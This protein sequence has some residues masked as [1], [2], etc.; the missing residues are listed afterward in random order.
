MVVAIMPGHLSTSFYHPS[1]F[2]YL[3]YVVVSSYSSPLFSLEM[4][5]Q[6]NVFR[7]A[8]S[9]YNVS[10]LV[11]FLN[12]ISR[13]SILYIFT[14]PFSPFICLE[15]CRNI[16]QHL[17]SFSIWT[18]TFH[19]HAS[20]TCQS[21]Y[22]SFDT[23]FSIYQSLLSFSTI[24]TLPCFP[25]IVK[26]KM[27]KILCSVLFIG[28]VSNYFLIPIE[29]KHIT[30]YTQYTSHPPCWVHPLRCLWG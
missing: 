24:F 20:I 23:A 21:S 4:R 25:G 28:A 16:G 1:I 19:L 9:L 3:P 2:I 6:D 26:E 22:L 11:P 13:T 5:L 10:F 30:I 15:R 7:S 17:H 29:R 18:F 14:R 27:I 12:I 8:L